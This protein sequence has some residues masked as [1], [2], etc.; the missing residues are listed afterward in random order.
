M[1]PIFLV[2]FDVPSIINLVDIVNLQAFDY[3]TP[4]RNFKEADYTAPIYTPQNRNPLLN[5]DADISY[6]YVVLLHRYFNYVSC[7]VRIDLVLIDPQSV[8]KRTH[9]LMDTV[10][11]KKRRTPFTSVSI[12]I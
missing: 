1:Q 2:Y 6:W 11:A 8:G 10:N 7:G 5:I 12:N 9:D 4:E 3:N